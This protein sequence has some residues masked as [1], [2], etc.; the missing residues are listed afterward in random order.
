MKEGHRADCSCCLFW[1][2]GQEEKEIVVTPTA[3]E[4]CDSCGII[5][6]SGDWP[7]CPHGQYSQGRFTPVEVDLGKG[8]KETITNVLDARRLER[9]SE[10]AVA[11]GKGQPIVF[12][13]FSQDKSNYD[14]NS[15]GEN[16]GP[17]KFSTRNRRGQPFVTVRGGEYK[18]R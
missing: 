10:K 14:K 8:R 7:F 16:P 11:E 6:E 4:T 9:E 3:P 15:L 18:G 5:L 1:E 17:G 2:E 12:R 13:A